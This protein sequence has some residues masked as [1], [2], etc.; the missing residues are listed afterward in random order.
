MAVRTGIAWSNLTSHQK[1][2]LRNPCYLAN[3]TT[4]PRFGRR[5]LLGSIVLTVNAGYE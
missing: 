2:A 1:V 4:H 5:L 3:E